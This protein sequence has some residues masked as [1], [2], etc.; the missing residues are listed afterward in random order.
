MQ[1]VHFRFQISDDE[2]TWKDLVEVDRARS[3]WHWNGYFEKTKVRHLRLVVLKP[4]WD[5][6]LMKL[7]VANL[8]Q[9]LGDKDG[10]TVQALKPSLKASQEILGF[11]KKQ[12]TQ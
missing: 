1:V 4:S 7:V 3:P 5:V 11:P 12:E 8:N 2:T 9:P 10:H 6:H